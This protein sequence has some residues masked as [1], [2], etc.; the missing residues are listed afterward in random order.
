MVTIPLGWWLV[1]ALLTIVFF[2]GWRLFGVRMQPQRGSMYP[3]MGGGLIE[4]GGYLVAALLAVMAW[5]VW[6][7]LT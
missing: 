5:L 6:A 1:P 2:G 4:L 3:D 7:L